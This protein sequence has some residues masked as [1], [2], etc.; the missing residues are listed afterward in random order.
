[1]L[2]VYTNAKKDCF[3]QRKK[4]KKKANSIDANKSIY[5]ITEN[6]DN[7]SCLIFYNII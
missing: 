5:V 1:M 4:K 7:K 3:Y 2:Y 6:R